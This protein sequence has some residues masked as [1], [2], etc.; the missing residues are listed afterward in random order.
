MATQHR[1]RSRGQ[2]GH[3][4]CSLGPAN[5][6]YLDRMLWRVDG[7]SKSDGERER[8]RERKIEA[9]ETGKLE[10]IRLNKSLRERGENWCKRERRKLASNSCIE[11]QS[12]RSQAG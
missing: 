12:I 6:T 7:V 8:E 1:R 9:R 4:G 10:S 11:A 2:R 3:R 5:G